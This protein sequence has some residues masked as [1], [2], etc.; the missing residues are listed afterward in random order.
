MAEDA[1]A[2]VM[3]TRSQFARHFSSEAAQTIRWDDRDQ[4]ANYSAAPV[5]HNI[6]DFDQAYIVYTSGSTG[7]PKGVA[8]E[9]RQILN[10]L[11]WMWDEYPFAPGEVSAQKTAISFVDS[12]WELLGPLLQGVPTVIIPDESVKDTQELVRTL[13]EHGVTRLWFVPSMLRVMLDQYPDL[14]RRLPLLRFWVSSGEPLT[15]GLVQR[16]QQMMPGSVLYNLYG[17]SEVWD[18]TWYDPQRSDSSPD[19]APIG[20]PIPNVEVYILDEGLQL[21]PRGVPGELY[22]GG[23]ALARGY[24]NRPSLN[25]EKFIPHPFSTEPGA[26]LYKSGDLARYLP[27]GNIEFLGRCDQQVKIRGYRIELEEIESLLNL[28]R[29]VKQAVVTAGADAAGDYRLVG[30]VVSNNGNSSSLI[31][32]LR[33]YLELHLPEHM[34]PS[35]FV[36]MD[37]LPLTPSGKIDRRALPAPVQNLA[38]SENTYE[39]PRTE[40]EETLAAMYAEV[41]GLERVGLHDHFFRDLGGHSMVATQMISRLRERLEIEL[42]LRVFFEAPTVARLAHEIDKRKQDQKPRVPTIKPIA[43]ENYRVDLSAQGD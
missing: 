32:N 29:E 8:V 31:G 22:V 43:R 13:A 41:L 18:V 34:V 30:Y 39:A 21:L 38:E 40:V 27:D 12:I 33:E 24:L 1:G 42:P 36:L 19:K 14:Q 5:A 25:V 3:I 20:T 10:R 37:D 16:F 17:T 7:K 9:H 26:R 6:Q 23:V 4:F 2:S 11:A 35:A 28:H 15:P